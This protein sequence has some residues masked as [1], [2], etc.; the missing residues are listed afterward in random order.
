M[1]TD[2]HMRMIGW[3][4]IVGLTGTSSHAVMI[5][6]EQDRAATVADLESREAEATPEA[7]EQESESDR[8]SGM[9]SSGL[10]PQIRSHDSGTVPSVRTLGQ[11]RPSAVH[12][13]R[14]IRPRVST[15]FVLANVNA[16]K[17]LGVVVRPA[18]HGIHAPPAFNI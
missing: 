5:A 11:A 14:I 6:L 7:Q 13:T 1:M 15:R 18:Q 3:G 4:L 8:E 2:L 9:D 16:T 12:H 17:P 10:M